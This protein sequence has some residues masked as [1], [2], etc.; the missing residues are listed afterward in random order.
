MLCLANQMSS[1]AYSHVGIAAQEI[2]DVDPHA[3]QGQFM[4][5][6]VQAL[7]RHGLKES[8]ALHAWSHVVLALECEPSSK[9][10]PYT[11]RVCLSCS[12]V[13]TSDKC[14]PTYLK[15]SC[16]S[17]PYYLRDQL[18]TPLSK[19]MPSVHNRASKCCLQ[20]CSSNGTCS[21][22]SFIR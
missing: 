5:L 10:G 2:Q 7:N 9:L 8:N 22:P 11:M 13:S 1:L 14:S 4:L 20:F 21:R 15:P 3:M 17:F 12:G 18:P 16:C 6:A 19:V